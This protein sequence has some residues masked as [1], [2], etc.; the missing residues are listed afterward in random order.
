MAG[1][2]TANFTIGTTSTAPFLSTGQLSA[3]GF[4]RVSRLLLPAGDGVF[5][6]LAVASYLRAAGL[7]A[8]GILSALTAQKYTS[9]PPFAG[10]GAL[11]A[12]F[13]GKVNLSDDFNRADSNSVGSNWTDKT[14]VAGI[15]MGILSNGACARAPSGNS[16]GGVALA[17]HNTPMATNDMTVSYT[18]GARLGTNDTGKDHYILLGYNSSGEGVAL[19]FRNSNPVKIV[20]TTAFSQFAASSYTTRATSISDYIM[21]T[22]DVF[23]LR[24]VGNLYT[25]LKNGGAIDGGLTW[26]DSGNVVPRDNSHLQTGLGNTTSGNVTTNQVRLCDSWSAADI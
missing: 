2:L 3:E 9:A 1:F 26:S 21:T 23:T 11:S 5:D 17:L 13:Y 19:Q 8:P 16:T 12:V 24:R 18:L 7:T 6:P 15:T 25:A 10:G 20:T 22:T 14:T 4:V